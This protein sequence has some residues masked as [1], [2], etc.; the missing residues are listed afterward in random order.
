M[1]VLV[2]QL[3]VFGAAFVGGMFGAL[4]VFPLGLG[5]HEFVIW[6]LTLIIGALFAAILAAWISTL[7]APDQMRSRL[8]AIVGAV[9]AI[10]VVVALVYL[11]TLPLWSMLPWIFSARIYSL[12]LCMLIIALSASWA[13][14]RYRSSRGRLGWARSRLGWDG[15]IMLGGA[16]VIAVLLSLLSWPGA[17]IGVPDSL[18][19]RLPSNTPSLIVWTGLGIVTGSAILVHWHAW[20]EQE[21]RRDAALTLGLIG[22]AP[23]VV[24]GTVYMVYIASA[25]TQPLSITNLSPL[26]ISGQGNTTLGPLQVRVTQGHQAVSGRAITWSMTAL[27]MTTAAIEFVSKDDTT[28]AQGLASA[29]VRAFARNTYTVTASIGTRGCSPCSVAFTVTVEPFRSRPSE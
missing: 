10:A 2:H 20:P 17:W 8:L 29:Q 1:R 11:F 12:G 19:L 28:N 27:P 13:T 25:Q 22:L 18:Y 14:S 16:V 24:I 3:G 15:G 23:L 7:L 5:V 21:L 4:S 6:P 9:E 26:S